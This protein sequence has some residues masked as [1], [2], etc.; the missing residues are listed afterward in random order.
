[1]RTLAGLLRVVRKRTFVQ[2]ARAP[3]TWILA[4]VVALHVLGLSWG[5][6]GSDGWDNDGVAP[7]YCSGKGDEDAPHRP[8]MS[9]AS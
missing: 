6:P 3:M 9:A 7:R 4:T 8:R 2:L 5:L 1:V